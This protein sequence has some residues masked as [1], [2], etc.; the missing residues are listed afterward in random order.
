MNFQYNNQ[1]YT[2]KRYPLSNNSSL[3]AW[4]AADEH[5]L[6]YIEH[7]P[8][9]NTNVTIIN[10][11]FGFL[12]C[13]LHPYQPNTIWTNKS[14]QKATE[15]NLRNNNIAPSNITFQTI[16][17]PDLGI[18]D[19]GFLKIPK[20]L[21]L[22]RLFL[23]QLSQSANKNTIVYCSFMTRHFSPKILRIAEDFFE[24][25]E[26]SKAWKKSRVLLLKQPKAHQIE[27]LTHKINW[28]QEVFHQYFGVFSAGHIDYA[29]Q[30]LIHNLPPVSSYKRVLDLASGNG[31]LAASIRKRNPT[32]E[33]HLLDDFFLAVESSKLNLEQNNTFFHNNDNL[34]HF[35]ANHFDCIISNPPFHFEH[36][37]NIDIS[38]SLF[39]EVRRSL[40]PNGHFILV[41]NK[42][43]NYKTHLDLLFPKVFIIKENKKFVVYQ[44][45]ISV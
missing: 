6:K 16:L 44:C 34:E 18:T 12:S 7:L 29:S 26:Q 11:R 24:H 35:P 43:L 28:E 31:I 17:S 22:F 30:F 8:Q 36:E 20:S 23:Y 2:I 4:S 25:I 21:A 15:Y 13:L 45:N 19:V 33:L 5:L 9:A 10:D 3:Q 27:T 40:A 32:C 42:H 41:A 38:L 1:S 39:K 14:H 37:V